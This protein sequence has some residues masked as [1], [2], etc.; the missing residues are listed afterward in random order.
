MQGSRSLVDA[1]SESRRCLRATRLA[2]VAGAQGAAQ[3]HTVNSELDTCRDCRKKGHAHPNPT[4]AHAPRRGGV[5]SEWAVCAGRRPRFRA[6]APPRRATAPGRGTC[7]PSRQARGQRKPLDQQLPAATTCPQ[8]SRLRPDSI[9][10]IVAVAAR[11]VRR[12]GTHGI[13]VRA[14]YILQPNLD[15]LSLMRR[16]KSSSCANART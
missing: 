4:R 9:G 15:H 13:R 14:R 12:E 6:G 11:G 1:R 16:L 3:L 2:P 7:I 10:E 5:P 8:V